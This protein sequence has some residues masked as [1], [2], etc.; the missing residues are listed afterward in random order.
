MSRPRRV[1]AR[2]AAQ[3]KRTLP[4]LTT[5]AAGSAQFAFLATEDIFWIGA[6]VIAL[7]FC[8]LVQLGQMCEQPVNDGAD[9]DTAELA[10]SVGVLDPGEIPPAQQDADDLAQV[11]ARLN[12]HFRRLDADEEVRMDG[13]AAKIRE[14]VDEQ[15]SSY[16][17]MAWAALVAEFDPLMVAIRCTCPRSCGSVA[18][19]SRSCRVH[20]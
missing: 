16:E 3:V 20:G 12:E 19:P 1:I 10:A 7:A 6:T 11:A 2:S 15:R 8:V 4:A 14:R 5:L 9:D 13:L 17:R 18:A